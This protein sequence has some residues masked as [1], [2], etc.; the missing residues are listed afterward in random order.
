[1]RIAIK[2]IL[3]TLAV[4]CL[5]AAAATGQLA[6]STRGPAS[7]ISAPG[8]AGLEE[9]TD[10]VE[11]P[12]PDGGMGGVFSEGDEELFCQVCGEGNSAPPNWYLDQ[13]IRIATRSRPRRE[14]LTHELFDIQ[15]QS[16]Q[17]DG[18]WLT[19][20]EGI[21]PIN[22]VTTRSL[23][24]D[25]SSGYSTT[26]GR[27]LGRDTD[28][29]DHFI[30]LSY[31]GLHSW[32]ETLRY[33][34]YR[35]TVD[36]R[37][38]QNALRPVNIGS[39]ISNFDYPQ[40]SSIQGS[41]QVGREPFDSTIGG[42]NRADQHTFTYGS[43]FNTAEFNARIRPRGRSDRLVLL[44][45][46]N[47]RRECRPGHYVSYIFGL[48]YLS[49]NE[50]FRWH[51][52][53]VILDSATPVGA[54]VSGDYSIRTHNDLVGLQVGG[55]YIYRNCKW[56]WGVKAKAGPY[57]N[58]A[59]QFSDVVTDATGDPWVQGGD[60]DIHTTARKNEASL[61]AELGF[62]GTYKIRPNITLQ[63]SYELM[64]ITGLALAAEQLRFERDPPDAIN[65]NGHAYHHGL[66]LGFKWV[67]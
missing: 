12:L 34:G 58:L 9:T 14:S 11:M 52:Q 22:Q 46:G 50:F 29:R 44:P 6:D 60:L 62:V 7:A 61:V 42:F 31:W 54:D 56:S 4:A 53:G 39:L 1:V 41:T 20:F 5:E 18:T 10:V 15:T 27:H 36:F 24:F 49:V 32:Q 3:V 59:D 33:N 63:A 67:R 37:N 26:L 21:Q 23:G 16:L 66:S 8:T 51:S 57:V 13:Q 40:F 35:L 30:E 65:L 48:R 17:A 55:D 19:T 45:N 25:I 64:W 43:D 28:N 2:G 47:W 38:N